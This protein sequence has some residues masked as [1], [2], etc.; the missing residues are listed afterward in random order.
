[1]HFCIIAALLL[2]LGVSFAEW[3]NRQLLS[4]SGYLKA[5]STYRDP[6]TRLNHLL[7]HNDATHQTLHLAVDDQGQI[8]YSTV[9]GKTLTAP[10]VIH[11]AGDGKQL[12]V[13]IAYQ[14]KDAG[15]NAINFTEST[16]GGKTW[17]SASQITAADSESALQDM[18]YIAET[19][20]IMV[21]LQNSDKELRVTS[22]PPGSRAFT[23]PTLVVEKPGYEAGSF[24]IARAAYGLWTGKQALIHFFYLGDYNK[25]VLYYTRSKNN[26]VGWSKPRALMLKGVSQIVGVRALGP[27]LYVAYS[28]SG[29]S[30][31]VIMKHSYNYGENFEYSL[32]VSKVGTTYPQTGLAVCSSHGK[33]AMAALIVNHDDKLEYSVWNTTRMGQTYGKFP[34]DGA[35]FRTAAL[36]CEVD[37]ERSLLNVSTFAVS[38]YAGTGTLYFARESA[39]LPA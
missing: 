22:R 1:M 20:R 6:V 9:F 12:F 34:V 36:D 16:D 11:G 4:Q 21:F 8:V 7:V 3:T 23:G 28:L 38:Y 25:D 33:D 18:I 24:D 39:P 31:K 27:R 5:E 17:T 10:A 13:A 29:E 37:H 14:A 35:G 32:T 2:L 19:G 26:G 15:A 30:Q